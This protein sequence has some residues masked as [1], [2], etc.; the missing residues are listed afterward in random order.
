M[1]E[2][3][4]NG[5]R[6]RAG[7]D[8]GEPHLGDHADDAPGCA[9]LIQGLSLR[10]YRALALSDRE[11]RH[12]PAWLSC[13]FT[14]KSNTVCLLTIQEV[15]F[16]MMECRRV[17]GEKWTG[18]V[19]PILLYNGPDQEQTHSN[20]STSGANMLSRVDASPNCSP[21]GSRILYQALC[22]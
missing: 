22:V 5:G 7:E 1:F 3:R 16:S 10:R 8:S 14:Y 11:R 4:K 12:G 19:L 21:E 9:G 20:L 15:S 17:G 6:S 18:S 13:L 2:V